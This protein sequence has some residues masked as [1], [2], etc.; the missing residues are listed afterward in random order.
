M[1]KP[2]KQNITEEKMI[3][4]ILQSNS[5]VLFLNVEGILPEK[6]TENFF[7]SLRYSEVPGLPEKILAH[8]GH[9]CAQGSPGSAPFAQHQII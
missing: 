8:C 3:Y 7:K 1:G 6:T 4:F 2:G 5:I 9:F